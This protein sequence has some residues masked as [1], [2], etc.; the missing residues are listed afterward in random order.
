MANVEVLDWK[1]KKVSTID[2]DEGVFN[3]DVRKNILHEVVKWQLACRR[4]GTHK[5]KTRAMVR[6]GGKKPFKQK[7]TGNARQ[8]STRSPLLE[9]GGVIFG[10]APRDYSYVLPK[11][12]KRLGLKMALSYLNKNGKLSV[13]DNMD[14]TE[15]KTGELNK[16][17]ADFG[18]NKA[19]LVDGQVNEKFKR[20]SENLKNFKYFPVAGL[21]VFDLLKYNHVIL[22]KDSVESV[23]QRCA[24]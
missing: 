17:L 2:L 16:R 21:N 9:G 5:A 13:V 4:Q 15:G 6:G 8:G 20:A 24:N 3:C 23:T 14:S 1:K 18:V 7:G 10:P 12:V 22:T 11:K 19:I